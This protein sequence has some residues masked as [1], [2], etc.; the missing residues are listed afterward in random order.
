MSLLFLQPN[1]GLRQPRGVNIQLT[2]KILGNEKKVV[3]SVFYICNFDVGTTH[4]EK[5]S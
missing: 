5:F 2:G 1:I 3:N 4:E